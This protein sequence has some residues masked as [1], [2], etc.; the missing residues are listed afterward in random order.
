MAFKNVKQASLFIRQA[1]VRVL[2]QTIQQI[3]V[4]TVTANLTK[5]GDYHLPKYPYCN[6]GIQNFVIVI[7]NLTKPITLSSNLR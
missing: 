7:F 3:K 2:W 1:Q 6:R 5:V 4:D